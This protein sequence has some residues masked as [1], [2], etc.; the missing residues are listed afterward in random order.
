MTHRRMDGVRLA[1]VFTWSVVAAGLTGVVSAQG[2]PEQTI[3]LVNP[4]APGGSADVISRIVT[5][6]MSEDLKRQIVVENKAGAGGT[7]GSDLVA[8]SP[9]DGYTLILSTVASHGIATSL[10]PNLPYNAL[11]DFEHIAIIDTLPNALLVGAAFPAANLKELIALVKGK[12]GEYTYGSAGNGSS[13]HLSA[14]MLLAHAGVKAVHVPYKGAGPALQALLGRET[15]FLFENV[16]TIAEYVKSGK[17]RVLGTT[18]ATRST[19]LPDVPTIREQGFPNYVAESWHGFAAPARTP[20]AIVN[21]LN[22]AVR[23]AV[24]SPAL[25]ARLLE[26]GVNPV[27]YTPAQTREFVKTEIERWTRVVIASGAKVD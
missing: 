3:R 6:K 14:E 4:W 27:S 20:A 11:T 21:R 15:S 16:P 17:L 22:A 26:L 1:A 18:G 13:P 2:Y 25:K 9:P 19:M 24:E 8:K 23:A 5:A 7:V 12:P 10:Y